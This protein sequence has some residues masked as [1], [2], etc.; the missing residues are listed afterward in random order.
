M[1]FSE[2]LSPKQLTTLDNKIL[3]EKAATLANMYRDDL[4]KDELSV[5]IESFKY[6]VIGT[7]ATS[8]KGSN[9]VTIRHVKKFLDSKQ[10]GLAMKP[11][12]KFILKRLL[13]T[14][15]LEKK[16]GKYVIKKSKKKSPG[17]E[18]K[19]S[20]SPLR[21]AGRSTKKKPQVCHQKTKQTEKSNGCKVMNETS[22]SQQQKNS[23]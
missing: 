2:F 16:D 20:K 7:L 4:D 12:T 23:V 10:E 21:K 5:E 9:V 3:R 11:E 6:S 19:R 14:G 15:H 18:T 13:E 17:K 8:V 1:E 22:L